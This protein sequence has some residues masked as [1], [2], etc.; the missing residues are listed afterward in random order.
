MRTKPRFVETTLPQTYI[1]ELGVYLQT[2]AQIEF[3]VSSAICFCKGLKKDTPEWKREENQLR[4]KSTKDLINSL[5]RA[6]CLLE[7]DDDWQAYF[8]QLVS[9]LHRYAEN[10]HF[11][12]HGR[13]CFSEQLERVTVSA[14]TRNGDFAQEISITKEDVEAVTEDADRIL[15]SLIS[16][17]EEN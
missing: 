13:H 10:R 4:L 6:S 5:N 11:A 3:Y 7:E 16:F 17:V 9:W 8:K 2:C 1:Y 15:R 12:V 14:A